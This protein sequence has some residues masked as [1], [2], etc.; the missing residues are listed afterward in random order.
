MAWYVAGSCRKGAC[1]GF[2]DY[3]L[4]EVPKR[5]DINEWAIEFAKMTESD[6]DD[7]IITF[8]AKTDG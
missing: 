4:E 1:S 6:E 7:M 3:P 2:F 5:K 8:F